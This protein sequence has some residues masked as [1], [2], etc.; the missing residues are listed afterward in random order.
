MIKKAIAIFIIALV[1]MWGCGNDSN[2]S[3][4]ETSD[5]ASTNDASRF[6]VVESNWAW[7]IVADKEEGVM[8]AVSR[9]TY[10]IG[11]FTVLLDKNGRPLIWDGE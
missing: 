11:N 6:V 4:N 1:L 10:N 5:N 3:T 8:Y 2:T 7:W 9:G